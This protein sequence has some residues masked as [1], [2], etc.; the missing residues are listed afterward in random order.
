MSVTDEEFAEQLWTHDWY[1]IDNSLLGEVEDDITWL[2]VDEEVRE[3]YR[4]QVQFIKF[5]QWYD[6]AL[7]EA[8]HSWI[9]AAHLQG[10]TLVGPKDKSAGENWEKE[11]SRED[12]D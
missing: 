10:Y 9:R 5:S 8:I 3:S 2:E 1:K 12:R 7:V 6:E 11:V 4:E